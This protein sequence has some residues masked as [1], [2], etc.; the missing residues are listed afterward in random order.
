MWSEIE[1]GLLHAVRTDPA[2]ALI[3]DLEAKV[4]AAEMTPT[5]A[6]EA[7]LRAFLKHGTT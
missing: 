5:A 7:V 1:A 6:A 2:A 3:S 4:T